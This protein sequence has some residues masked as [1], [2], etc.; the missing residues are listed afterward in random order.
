MMM[1][2]T[3]LIAVTSGLLFFTIS[4]FSQ[5]SISV[6]PWKVS[7]KK[8]SD[9]TYELIFSTGPAGDWKLYS[10]DQLTDLQ[11]TELQF[12]N[13]TIRQE[14]KFSET[15]KADTVANTLFGAAI[16]YDSP[17][18]WTTKIYFKDKDSVPALLPGKLLYTYGKEPDFFYPSTPFSFIVELEGGIKSASRIK[19][20]S[21]DLSHPVMP[22]GDEGTKNK[23]ILSIFLLGILGGLIALLTPCVFPMVPV[24]VTF[25][26]K[27]SADRKK[28]I[29][30]AA[31]YG[32]FI[33]LIYALITVPFH[34]ASKTISPEIFNNISTNVVLNFIF[35]TVFVVFALS[36]FGL[37]EIGLPSGLANRAGAKSGLGNVAGIFFMAGTLAIVSFSC[38]GPILGTLLANVAVEGAWPLTAGAAGFGLALGLPFALFA[39]F[40]NWLRSLPKS[41][42]WMEEVKVVLGFIELALAVKFFSNADLVKQWG[43]L[44]RE[45]FIALWVIIGVCIVIYLLRKLWVRKKIIP[46]FPVVRILFILLF[47]AT[48]AYLVPGLTNTK[49]A[50]L[51]LISGFPP[52]LC[53]SIY[54]NPVNCKKGFKPLDDYE[55]AIAKAKKENKPVLIDF[56]GWACVNCRKMEE[57]IWTDPIVDSFMHKEYVVVSLYVDEKRNLPVIDQVVFKTSSGTNKSIVTVGDKWATFQ[58]ENFGAASQ[59]QYAIISPD[60]KALTKTKFYTPDAVEFAAWLQCGIDAFKSKK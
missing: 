56:T 6:F 35:F 27:R 31:L 52:P 25:F 14:G 40:P 37:F 48:T 16:I 33:F 54:E 45:I 17:T 8:I 51:K 11:T 39:M 46:G 41:G 36:F 18:E 49:S 5:D 44:K 28:G 60:E 29:A 1:K 23:S 59:P 13:S 58:T 30:N 24:T 50:N 10:P 15:G 32:F 47:L 38:T 21:I 22:C 20:N 34:I 7:G 12:N 4:L 57:S 2:L 53:Y 26:T 3:R 9:G 43:L 55:A 42:G 19:I